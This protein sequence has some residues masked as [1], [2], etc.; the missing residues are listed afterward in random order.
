MMLAALIVD[1]LFSAVDLTPTDRPTRDDV[2]GSIEVDYKLF[3]NLAG[4][5]VFAALMFLTVR[6]GATDPVCGMKVD[7]AKALTLEVGGRT[8]Y[9]C[10]EHCRAEFR[11]SQ[12]RP[13]PVPT[14]R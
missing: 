5:V 14:L 11:A 13:G 7:R 6:R 9:F 8:R 3:L 1:G 10:S 12:E 4:A 2:F